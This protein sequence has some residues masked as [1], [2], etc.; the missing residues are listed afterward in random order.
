MLLLSRRASA[1]VS[2]R[3]PMAANYAL[4]TVNALCTMHIFHMCIGVLNMQCTLNICNRVLNIQLFHSVPFF[5]I[6]LSNNSTR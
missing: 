2:E 5:S 4:C 3:W 6:I 1:S